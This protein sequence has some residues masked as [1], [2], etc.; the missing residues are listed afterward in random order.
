MNIAKSYGN[1]VRENLPENPE[2]A[3]R[4][5]R[6]GLHL[7]SFRVAHFSDKR[8]P[9]AYRYLNKMADKAVADALDHPETCAWTNIFAPSE[10]LQTFG[11]N[12]VSM[13]CLASFLSGFYLEDCFIDAAENTGIASTLCSYHKNFIGAL[14]SGILPDAAIGVTT[15]MVCDGNIN[16]FRF[17]KKKTGI[18]TAVL[19][20]PYTWSPEAEQY[21]V[22]QLEEL[23][24]ILEKKT[25]RRY[26]EAMLSEVLKRENESKEH[27]KSFLE[28]RRF[29]AYPNTMTLILYMLFATHLNIGSEWVL[30]F[31]RKMDEEID[32]YPADSGK[33]LFWIH[34]EPYPEK[35][36]REYLN[37]GEKCSIVCDD[38]NMD[39]M[40]PLD[41]SHPLN[42][43]A[44]KMICNIYN[45]EFTR[46]SNAVCNYVKQYDCDGAV[47]FCHWGCRQSGG[48]VMMMKEKLR[49]IG[50]PMLVL[51]GDAIDR[52]NLPDGQI[53]TRFEA[54]LELLEGRDKEEE[55]QEACK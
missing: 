41:T 30:S 47:E 23:I 35:S 21:V 27:F 37:Y 51:D 1:M 7:E 13:E 38:F 46:K 17:L 32:S 55:S 26:D 44:R 18:E 29:H 45:G 53:R 50:R 34:V 39:Y 14:V 54:F 49:S 4:Q 20:I 16:T 52:R 40:E 33:R 10:L 42:A 3:A 9:E 43:L 2:K 22:Q 5:I 19:D 12:C 31:F 36:L 28:K 15:S 48:G 8:M 11:L 6:Q 25:G 24:V